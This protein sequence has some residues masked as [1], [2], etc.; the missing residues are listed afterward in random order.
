MSVAVYPR[1][2]ALLQASGMS[3]AELERQIEQR[4]GL[5]VDAKTLYRLTHPEP[6]QRADM[7]VAGAAAAVLGV[8][9]GDL[10]EV[11]ALPIEAADNAAAADLPPEQSRRL[12]ELFDRQSRGEL[13]PGERQELTALVNEWGRR[14]HEYRLREIAARRG[15]TVEE[16]RAQVAADLDHALE[17]WRKFEAD[18]RRRRAVINRARR[19]R[20]QA[21]RAA[22]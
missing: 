9:I 11:Q 2:G 6:V 5:T 4:Y 21:A 16:A 17:W 10:F 8:G 20:Q 1:L 18:P 19:E 14:Q 22:R 3:V 13:I 15:L 7:A 12:A